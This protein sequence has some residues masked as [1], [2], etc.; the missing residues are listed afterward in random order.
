M[1]TVYDLQFT[2]IHFFSTLI[3]VVQLRKMNEETTLGRIT[4]IIGATIQLNLGG[5]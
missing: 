4:I 3:I 2:Y 5:L 1:K